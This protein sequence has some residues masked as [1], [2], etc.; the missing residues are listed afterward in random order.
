[1]NYRVEP[2]LYAVGQPD[3]QSPVLVSANYKL[4]FDRL[5][6]RLAG[7]SVWIL[8][9]DTN[10]INVWCAAGKGTFGADEIVRCVESSRLSEVVAHR[11][12]IVPQLGA[13]RRRS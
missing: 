6:C 7:L 13:G 4:S 5:R 11:T 3:P 1:M 12:L 2:G 8:V 9:I 10:G